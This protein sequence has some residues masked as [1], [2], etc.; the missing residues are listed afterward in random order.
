VT[1]V[2]D[3]SAK[4]IEVDVFY[5]N[6]IYSAVVIQWIPVGGSD[7]TPL[8]DT[9]R[10]FIKKRMKLT[11]ILEMVPRIQSSRRLVYPAVR[12]LYIIYNL[13]NCFIYFV[14]III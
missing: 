2:N 1:E 11:K 14:S 10:F 5:D 9:M 6:K 7:P 3:F 12:L 4:Y 8:L 13:G